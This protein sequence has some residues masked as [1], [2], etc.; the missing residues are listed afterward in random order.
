[1]TTHQLHEF[2][3]DNSDIG[4]VIQSYTDRYPLKNCRSD[5]TPVLLCD[6]DIGYLKTKKRWKFQDVKIREG[7]CRVNELLGYLDHDYMNKLDLSHCNSVICLEDMSNLQELHCRSTDIVCIPDDLPSLKILDCSDTMID[8]IPETLTNLKKLVCNDTPIDCVPETLV[9]L[10]NL[11]C[12][13]SYITEIPKELKALRVLR[14]HDG[15]YIPDTILE[16]L[17]KKS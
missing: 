17:R 4:D 14:T 2:V 13:F 7:S 8:Y 3:Y 15:C 1:M 12:I 10:E 16:S 11:D 9:R 5:R 6:D